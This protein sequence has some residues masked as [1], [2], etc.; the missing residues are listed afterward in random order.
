MGTRVHGGPADL[1]GIEEAG[2]VGGWDGFDEHGVGNAGNEMTNV[3]GS[4]K[5]GHGVAVGRASV[6]AA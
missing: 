2:S 4:L 5:R 6:S 1:G 3:L